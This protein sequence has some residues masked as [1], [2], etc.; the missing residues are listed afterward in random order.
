[1]HQLLAKFHESVPE[2]IRCDVND[3]LR[4]KYIE[5][6]SDGFARTCTPLT[7][8]LLEK[9]FWASLHIGG[10]EIIPLSV[11]VDNELALYPSYKHLLLKAMRNNGLSDEAIQK[12]AP[13]LLEP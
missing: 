6:L 5:E 9:G 11:F 8:F 1:M 4:A 2:D 13:K 10:F 7:E 12:F 3:F